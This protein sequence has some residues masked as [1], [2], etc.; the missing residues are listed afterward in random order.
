[1]G[2]FT[3]SA[4]EEQNH[5]AA[6]VDLMRQLSQSAKSVESPGYYYGVVRERRAAFILGNRG[7]FFT[8]SRAD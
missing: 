6:E 5:F 1:V 4:S 3:K 2:L 8:T 7:E